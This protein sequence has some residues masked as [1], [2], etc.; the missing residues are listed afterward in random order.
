MSVCIVMAVAAKERWTELDAVLAKDLE[1]LIEGFE[2]KSEVGLVASGHDGDKRQ[3]VATDGDDQVIV[4]VSE[5]IRIPVG[6]IAPGGGGGCVE[7]VVAA[8]RT[9]GAGAGGFSSRGGSGSQD[10]AVSSQDEVLLLLKQSLANGG[11]DTCLSEEILENSWEFAM[12]W[13]I[14]QGEQVIDKL[15]GEG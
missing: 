6:V 5:Y 2:R 11:A 9:V 10:R 13:F 1:H 7:A 3:V 12:T 8:G 15:F 14:G 4:A